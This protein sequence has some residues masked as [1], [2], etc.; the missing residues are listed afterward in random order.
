MIIDLCSGLGRWESAKQDVISI[1]ANPKTKPTIVADIHHLPLRPK[2]KPSL[3]WASP[4]CTYFTYARFGGFNRETG[5]HPLGIAYSLRLVAACFEAINYLEP[6][7]WI[8][9]NPR[10]HLRHFL[11]EPKC[12]IEYEASDM[13]H[14]VTDLFSDMRG[15][16]RA[17]VPQDVRNKIL[18]AID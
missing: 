17:M 3:V 15:L 18:A 16:K 13:K 9:E 7:H 4:P 2:L 10:G 5:V 14:K 8:I 1:D 12:T 11:F 6:D